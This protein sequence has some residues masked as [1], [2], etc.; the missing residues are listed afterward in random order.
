MADIVFTLGDTTYTLTM[1]V[2]Y[3]AILMVLQF[4]IT[5]SGKNR[6]MRLLPMGINTVVC[7]AVALG[8]VLENVSEETGLGMQQ[9][10]FV[11]FVWACIMI[12][13]MLMDIV[14]YK[15]LEKLHKVAKG[16]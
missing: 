12:L 5:V 2:I 1:I 7:G 6:K 3:V 14:G 4:L 16:K 15:T 13:M 9:F 11:F 10:M 8:A